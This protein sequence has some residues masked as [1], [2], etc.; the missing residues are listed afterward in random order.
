MGGSTS[1]AYTSTTG[2][3]WTAI[4]SA[5]TKGVDSGNQI[6]WTGSRF[7]FFPTNSNNGGS[8]SATGATWTQY[9][10]TQPFTLQ[11]NPFKQ[12]RGFVF[13]S[14][15]IT[16]NFN[17]ATQKWEL[18]K[19][20]LT[21]MI[22]WTTVTGGLPNVG[23]ARQFGNRCIWTDTAQSKYF[24]VAG[25][26]VLASS[27]DLITWTLESFDFGTASY[28]MLNQGGG[29]WSFASNGSILIIMP[30]RAGYCFRSA[31]SGATW[32]K[33]PINSTSTYTIH[34]MYWTGTLFIGLSTNASIQSA[35]GLTWVTSLRSTRTT[36]PQF[37][38]GTVKG[39]KLYTSTRVSI[40]LEYI[41]TNEWKAYSL[42]TYAK[43]CQGMEYDSVT[44]TLAAVGTL[45]LYVSKDHGLS[46]SSSQSFSTTIYTI[47]QCNGVWLATLPTASISYYTSTDLVTWVQRASPYASAILVVSSDG[48]AFRIMS[49]TVAH[50]S[51]GIYMSADGINWVLNLCT[52]TSTATKGLNGIKAFCDIGVA[53]SPD[54]NMV[55]SNA[56]NTTTHFAMPLISQ[57]PKLFVRAKKV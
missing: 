35:D 45:G 55:T 43:A 22:T 28:A 13:G 25:C 41:E 51:N 14:N 27:T 44:G 49:N 56:Y 36:Y 57:T 37:S 34:S 11:T 46:F 5:Y 16:A 32:S 53:A 3:T 1:T 48:S 17:I 15:W 29:S 2:T 4:A 52:A 19:S 9:T 18:L 31:D 50:M 23:L 7:A 47:A 26:L 38:F 42:P 21:D 10:G 33:I 20:L 12:M 54:L 24:Q 39:G 6:V 8:W 30:S 40:C